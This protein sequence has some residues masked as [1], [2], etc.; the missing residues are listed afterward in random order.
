M[1]FKI[2]YLC[3][4]LIAA[5]PDNKEAKTVMQAMNST[6]KTLYLLK[7]LEIWTDAKTTWDD[8]K[9]DD[10]VRVLKTGKMLTMGLWM[11]FEN[12]QWLDNV[13]LL[14]CDMKQAA[15]RGSLLIYI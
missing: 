1:M 5:R 6:R 12:Q 8:R 14:K 3:K 9:G 15:I 2:R 10:L 13:G 4:V 7:S 11:L